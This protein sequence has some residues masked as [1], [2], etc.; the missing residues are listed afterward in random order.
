VLVGAGRPLYDYFTYANLLQPCAALSA[1][2]S[3]SP[4]A[5]FIS[6]T[7][8]ANRCTSLK[9]KGLLTSATVADQAN[10]ALSLMLGYGW[11]P[12]TTKLHASHYA[13]AT[14]S[15]VMTYANTY[16]R[17]SVAD[18]L[19]GFSFAGIDGAGRPAPVAA[20][21]L[22]QIFGTGNGVPPTSGIQI[23][24][25][26]SVGGA[27]RDGI[28]TSP[29][30]GV[31]DYNVDGALC[32][33]NLWT[34]TDAAAANVN[35]GV[36]ATLRNANLRGKPA[37]IVHGRSDTLVPP[38]FTSRPYFG[39]NRIAE[40]TKSKLVY[41]EVTNAQHFD[42]FIDNPA[43]GGYDSMFV[44][45]HY[46]FNQALDLVYAHLTSGGPL[47]PSQVVRTVPRGG[48]PGAAPQITNANVPP[49]LNN[50]GS[51]NLITFSDNTVTIPD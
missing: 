41:I 33:R 42:A 37:I 24:N 50:P 18:N 39:Q 26:L 44:P 7:A 8:A 35:A 22:A 36:N 43:L 34:G 17:S 47:P 48:T 5:A 12:E 46:Y 28:S 23:I 49:I 21:A 31:Q 11:D 40:G 19:C 30:T 3:G 9:A 14:P 25:N 45:L 15:I 32:Q 29:S 27:I 10:E 2:A 20:A 13:F 16:G 4:G 1:N 38:A 51:S 6:A